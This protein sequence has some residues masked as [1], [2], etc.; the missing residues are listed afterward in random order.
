MAK[1]KTAKNITN[2]KTI[3]RTTFKYRKIEERIK[4]YNDILLQYA[5]EQLKD[6]ASRCQNC[7]VPFCHG[8]GCPLSNFIPD[9]NDLVYR[10]RWQ[11]ASDLLH[12][13]NNFPEITGI[14][15]PA[16]CE[17]A[18]TLNVGMEPVTIR[19]IELA[20]VEKAFKEGWIKPVIPKTRTNK[21]IAV[22]GSGPAGL[23]AAQNLN[24]MGHNVTIFERDQKAGGFLRY[25]I[26]DFK[27]EKRILDRRLDQ[28]LKEG[29]VIKTSCY[30]GYDISANYLLKN[31]DA[32]ILANG[33]RDP[34]DINIEGR[35]QKGIH[36]AVEYLRQSNMR[37]DGVKFNPEEIIDAGGKNVVVIGGGDTGADCIGTARRQGAKNIDQWEILPK[38]PEGR[39][40]DTPWPMYSKK[41]RTNSSQEEGCERKWCVMTKSFSGNGSVEKIDAVEVDWVMDQSGK[42]QMKEKPGTE[43][44]KKAELVL[45]AMGFTHTIHDNLL[46]DLNIELDKSGNIKTSDFGFG[47][48]SNP[49]VF[50][51]GDASRGASLVV[52]AIAHGRD[53][54]ES[55][56]KYLKGL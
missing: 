18:C 10:N 41:L 5:E 49:R 40:D 44:E 36:L 50:S 3:P 26:P 8:F 24:R 51:A 39:S 53:A 31:F 56:D 35:D 9:W 21:N 48:T 29:V 2:F 30:A 1:N 7:G 34:R 19:N 47:V 42:W 45:L 33:S 14:V 16:L 23:A 54:A 11:E 17:E 28:L 15:C 38:P 46:K 13:T 43:F 52:W 32:V 22:I 20:I 25:G 55:V 12:E 27:L 4:D 37:V 6:Q